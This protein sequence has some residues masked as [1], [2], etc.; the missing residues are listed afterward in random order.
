MLSLFFTYLLFLLIVFVL[1]RKLIYFPEVRTQAE[2][3]ALAKQLNLTLWPADGDYRGLLADVP[4]LPQGTV[5]LF[6]GN[7]G[8]A[9]YRRAY[10]D[11]L[12]NLGYRI[13]LAEYPG[14]GARGGNPTEQA[15]IDDGIETVRLALKTFGEP[16]FLWGESL[17]SGVVSGIIKSGQVPVEG[18]VLITPFKSMAAVAG[19][20]YWYFLGRW[21]IRDRYDNIAN[22]AGYSGPVAFVIAVKDEVVPNAHTH[23]LYES[24]DGPKK[25]WSFPEA[26]HNSLPLSPALPWWREVMRFVHAKTG[27]SRK[28]RFFPNNY[29]AA[30]SRFRSRRVRPK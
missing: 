11:A 30:P 12:G 8:S 20:H 5:V 3:Q 25:L 7:A 26:D 13:V 27:E 9:D 21:L 14:Y 15:L 24:L 18:I 1:Q 23:S 4:N 29:I 6:H 10:A 17:G 28:R 19:H 16:L 2:Q 22:L